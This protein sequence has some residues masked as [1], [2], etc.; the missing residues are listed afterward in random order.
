MLPNLSGPVKSFMQ[1]MTFGVVT[2]SI[3]DYEETETITEVVTRGVRQ[4]LPPQRLEIYSEGQRAWK[5]ECL[6][7]LPKPAFNPD[8]IV[9][10]NHK[11][12]R[13]VEKFDC[14]EYGYIEYLIAQTFED[15]EES[16]SAGE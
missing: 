13:V 12:Y 11:R 5:W 15:D 7:L 9:I 3:V 6:H 4:P 16:S 10:W 8:D 14:S 1:R 2:K